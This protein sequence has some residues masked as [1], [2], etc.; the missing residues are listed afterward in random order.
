MTS[1]QDRRGRFESVAAEVYEPLQRYLRRRVDADDAADLLS[2]TLLTVWRR[3]D[4]V[5]MGAALPWVY[6]VARRNLANHR[7]GQARR[8]RLVEKLTAEAAIAPSPPIDDP[9]LDAALADLP[10]DDREL[11]RLWAWEGLEP[12][13]LAAAL[14]ITPNAASLR[15]SRARGRLEERLAR[16]DPPPAGQIG[17]RGTEEHRE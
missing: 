14:D 5:P 17:S 9:D 4:D 10:E 3:I 16:Q 1:D 12:R 15:L 6:G 2:D 8:L 11:L 13:D 7:R